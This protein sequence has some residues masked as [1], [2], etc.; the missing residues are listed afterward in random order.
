MTFTK[1]CV[2]FTFFS[3]KVHCTTGQMTFHLVTNLEWAF[4]LT[5]F[6]VLV[7]AQQYSPYAEYEDRSFRF[8]CPGECFLYGIF[9]G[10]DGPMVADFASQKIPAE[11]L[12]GQIEGKTLTV[13]FHFNKLS[14]H[15]FHSIYN[16]K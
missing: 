4:K 12:L 10:H 1:H 14:Q 16:L 9:D 5:R 6:I 8:S 7:V 15:I 2:I 11:L 13:S 3:C